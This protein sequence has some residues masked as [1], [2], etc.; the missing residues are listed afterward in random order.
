M[1][2][3]FICYRREDTSGYAGRLF[4]RLKERFGQERVFLDV[5]GIEPGVDFVE[6]ID[7]EVG[8]CDALVIMIGKKWLDCTDQDGQRRLDDQQDFIRLEVATALRRNIRVIPVLVQGAV[9]PKESD[10]PEEMKLLARRQAF[11]ISD[12]HWDNDVPELLRALEKV[13]T[14]SAG[15]R[16]EAVAEKSAAVTTRKPTL[17]IAAVVA[18]IVIAVAGVAVIPKKEHVNAPGTPAGTTTGTDASQAAVPDVTGKQRDIAIASLAGA[19]FLTVQEKKRTSDNPKGTVL[20]QQP[21]AGSVMLKNSMIELVV[22]ETPSAPEKK[23]EPVKPVKP[24]P[25]ELPVPV[26]SLVSLPKNMARETITKAGFATGIVEMVETDKY[27]PDTVISQSPP[28]GEKTK[29]GNAINL[30]VATSPLKQPT[31]GTGNTST[32]PT[33]WVNFG[34]NTSQILSYKN[35]RKISAD[36]VRVE[37]RETITN[38]DYLKRIIKIRQAKNLGVEG[39]ERYSYQISPVEFDCTNNKYRLLYSR[40]YDASGKEIGDWRVSPN[41]QDIP[42]GSKY[43]PLARRLCR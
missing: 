17:I 6:T 34:Q 10:L 38:K 5:A 37:T 33:G 15:N 20:S 12:S 11:E 40:D 8:S 1:K 36:S 21:I 32:A 27:R 43:E 22:A 14:P 39:Y 26:P 35:P 2:G 25:A 16:S 42:A 28:F 13:V 19:G 29:K 9:M 30:K 23:P 18:L 4:D 7:R 24:Q 3:I 31:S 41:W